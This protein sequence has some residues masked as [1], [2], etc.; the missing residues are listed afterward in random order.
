MKKRNYLALAFM[1]VF[2]PMIALAGDG[3]IPDY[4]MWIV[5]AVGIVLAWFLKSPWIPTVASGVTKAL[6][7]LDAILEARLPGSPGGKEIT[8]EEWENDIFPK[9]QLIGDI[10]RPLTK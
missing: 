5:T 10:L 2:V 6:R 7:F 3:T 1:F 8:P 9:L 4:V